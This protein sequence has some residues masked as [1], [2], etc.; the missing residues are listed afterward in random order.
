[1]ISAF[2]GVFREDVP[3]TVASEQRTCGSLGQSTG[4]TK[5]L[6]WEWAWHVP[7]TATRPDGGW[8]EIREGLSWGPGGHILWGLPEHYRGLTTFNLREMGGHW[9][10]F[11]SQDSWPL[12]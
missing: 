7:G 5:A 6:R 8:Y 1:M 10:V 9:R 2:R 11:E 12:C 3:K 4:C